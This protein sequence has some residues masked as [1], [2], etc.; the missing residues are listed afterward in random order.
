MSHDH[1]LLSSSLSYVHSIM[2]EILVSFLVCSCGTQS[3]QMDTSHWFIAQA[4]GSLTGATLSSPSSMLMIACCSFPV[5]TWA[6]ITHHQGK[7]P[8]LVWVGKIQINKHFSFDVPRRHVY[9]FNISNKFDV[10]CFL[11]HAIVLSLRVNLTR[12]A[13]RRLM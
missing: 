12:W 4:C 8:S 5:S 9:F 2:S 3:G 13:R 6:H 10:G 1:L 7:L 11:L